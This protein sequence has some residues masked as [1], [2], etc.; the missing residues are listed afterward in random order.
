GAI[1]PH[2][3]R[4]ATPGGGPIALATGPGR[5]YQEGEPIHLETLLPAPKP[6]RSPTGGRGTFL[7]ADARMTHD[8]AFLQAVLDA[9]DDD[10]PRLMY[11]D[12]L[13]ERG[14][15]LGEFIRLQIELE[16]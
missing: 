13:T 10:A 11:A 5:A 16:R 3:G 7:A 4:G 2:P 1:V 12:W 6:G 9:P 14:D 8:E 15:P